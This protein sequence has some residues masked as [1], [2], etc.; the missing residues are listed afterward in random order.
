MQAELLDPVAHLIAIKAKE[1]GRV[2]LIATRALECLDHQ[3]TLDS[4]EIHTFGRQL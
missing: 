2:R 1:L 4:L 3:L